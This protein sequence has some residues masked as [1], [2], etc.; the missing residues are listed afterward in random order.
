MTL[1][2]GAAQFKVYEQDGHY[3][4]KSDEGFLYLDG[5]HVRLVEEQGEYTLFDL[6]QTENGWFV[7]STNAQYYGKAQ[8]LEYYGGYFTCYG[9]G[10]NTDLYTFQFLSL[11]HICTRVCA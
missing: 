8:Y 11:I 2:Q 10:S 9:M 6:E 7:K 5:T 1:P 4:L 3:V